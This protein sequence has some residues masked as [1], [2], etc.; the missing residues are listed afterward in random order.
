[1]FRINP[2]ANQYQ[3]D[4]IPALYRRVNQELATLPGVQSVALTR[5]TL[6]SGGQSTTRIH[7][8][9]K[10]EPNDIHVMSVSPE[11]FATLQIPVLAG[12]GF[13]ERDLATPQSVVIV[14]QTAVKQFFDGPDAVGARLGSTPEGAAAGEHEVVGVIKDTKYSNLRDAAPPTM[15]RV[16]RND[17]ASATV[18]VRTA[19]DPAAMIDSVRATLQKIDPELPLINVTTQTDQIEGRVAQERL[20]AL[21]YTLFGALALLLAS[22]GLFGLMSYNVSRRTSEIGIRMAL[23]AQRTGV[24]GMILR[25]S[26]LMVAVGAVIGLAGAFA[27]GRYIESVLFGLSKTDAWTIGAVIVLTTLVSLAA[28]YLPARR[29]ARVDPMVALRYEG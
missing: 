2:Q 7:I 20:F 14:N 6:L 3:N 27:A 15:Y 24:I 26:M 23:G 16:L 29:A 25:E 18:M 12:R 28:G 1:M 9:G 10:A 17:A 22:I 21:A 8:Q 19:G 5:T 11:F 13:A 4:R